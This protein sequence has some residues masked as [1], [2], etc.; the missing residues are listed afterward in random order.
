MK[1]SYKTITAPG[2]DRPTHRAVEEV[3]WKRDVMVWDDARD[4]AS[5]LGPP[6]DAVKIWEVLEDVITFFSPVTQSPVP[7]LRALE[8]RRKST[9][10]KSAQVLLLNILSVTMETR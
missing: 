4:P 7:H 1:H 2:D 6:Q 5:V 3:L 10:R 8:D 9:S